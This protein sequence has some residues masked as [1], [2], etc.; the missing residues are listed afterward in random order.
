[1]STYPSSPKTLCDIAQVAFQATSHLL[2]LDQSFAGQLRSGATSS[3]Q[4]IREETITETLVGELASKFSS[5][6]EVNLFTQSEESHN[7]AD[8]YWRIE[9]GS[10]AIHA[11]VQAKRI[12]RSKFGDLDEIGQIT[13]DKEQ[14]EKLIN[15]A[16]QIPGLEA[17]FAIYA[18]FSATPLCGYNNLQSCSNHLHAGSCK[19]QQPS[20]WVAKAQNIQKLAN[21]KLEIRQVIE[22]SLRLDCLLPCIGQRHHMYSQTNQAR[23]PGPAM[24]GFALRGDLWSY[25]DCVGSISN[26]PELFGQFRGALRIKL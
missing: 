11:R 16:S 17:W 21:S 22:N 5:H 2:S 20:V 10:D 6:I 24:K 25:E 4:F 19:N 13:I 15:G 23:S 9:R 8:W 14:L 26:N 3:R 18:R 12:Q 7:G 1:M